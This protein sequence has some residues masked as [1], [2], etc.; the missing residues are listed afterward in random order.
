M[1]RIRAPLETEKA[2][3]SPGGIKVNVGGIR[4]RLIVSVYSRNGL[5]F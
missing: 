2:L 4:C 5:A 1:I 3:A